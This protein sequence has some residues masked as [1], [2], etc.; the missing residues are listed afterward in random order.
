MVELRLLDELCE[1]RAFLQDLVLPLLLHSVAGGDPTSL[2][3]V[4]GSSYLARP[5][6]QIY[7]ESSR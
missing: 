4:H 2:E 5:A 3:T 1:L 6:Q 7:R